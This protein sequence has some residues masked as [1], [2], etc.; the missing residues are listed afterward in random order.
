[1]AAQRSRRRSRRQRSS[2]T[3]PRAVASP[4]REQRASRAAAEPVDLRSSAGPFGAYGERPSSPFGGLPI[5]ELGVL[6]GAVALVF[7]IVGKAPAA[8]VVGAI[9]CGLAVLEFT[10]REHFSGFRSHT[11]LL[12]AF[13]AIA[14]ETVVAL[15]ARP[16]SSAVLAIPVVPVFA[17]SFWLLR[18]RFLTARHARVAR[19]PAP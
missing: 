8:L 15:V 18:R 10:A 13:P 1:M 11:T 2:G 3:A 14:A 4:R 16:A 17:V 6:V 9:V 12:A 19:S 5:S 7:G